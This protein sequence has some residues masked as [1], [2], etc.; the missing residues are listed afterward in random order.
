MSAGA[1]GAIVA[2]DAT[3][4]AAAVASRELSCREVMEAHLARIEAVTAPI[5]PSSR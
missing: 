2:L 3:A 1:G 4:M 5:T